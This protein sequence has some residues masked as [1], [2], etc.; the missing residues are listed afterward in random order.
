MT[1]DRRRFL[2]GAGCLLYTVAGVELWL[3]PAEA[4]SR[5]AALRVLDTQ[6]VRTLEALGEILVPGARQAG[7]AHFV[8]SQLAIDTNDCLLIARSFNIEPP[9]RVFY[10]SVLAGVEAVSR[11]RHGK[12]FEALDEG[13]AIALVRE[14]SANDPEGWT[15]PPAP[16]GYVVIRSDAVDVVYGTVDGF[17]RL[18]VPY[19]PHI[20]PPTPW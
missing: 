4:R 20:L 2:Q 14:M 1:R 19:M 12:P 5:N 11:R 16:L 13:T 7:L 18:G 17:K 15:G 3:T 10:A 9:Y 6:Q 8:D